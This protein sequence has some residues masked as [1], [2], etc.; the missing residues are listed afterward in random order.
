MSIESMDAR[1][2]DAADVSRV[3]DVLCDSFFDYPVMRFVLGERDDYSAQL[4]TLVEFFTMARVLRNEVILGVPAQSNTGDGSGTDY[5]GVAL[6]SYPGRSEPPPELAE[7]AAATW[8]RV[9]ADSRRRYDQFSEACA[10]IGVDEP[11]I[12][13]NMIGTRRSAQGTGVGR[14]LLEAVHRLSADD[15]SSRGVSLSTESE[16]NV[17]LYEHFGYAVIGRATVAPELTT[18]GFYRPDSR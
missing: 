10:P 3:L 5:L 4:R 9:G 11:H 17:P 13:L 8:A 1:R 12:H 14:R 18:W 15:P 2:V 7:L 16:A 6:V